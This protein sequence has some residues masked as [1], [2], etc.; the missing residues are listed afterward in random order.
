LLAGFEQISGIGEKTAVAM[1]EY[2]T[3]HDDPLMGWDDYINVKG[4]GP[5]TMDK[6]RAFCED[7]D[8]FGVYRL[9][10]ALKKVR[11]YIWEYGDMEMLPMPTSKSEDVPYEPVKGQHTWVGI[12]RDRNLKDLYE[13]HRSRTGDELDPATVKEPEHVNWCVIIG[14]DET[15]PLTMT[16]HRYGGLYE[17]YKEAIWNINPKRDV[18][19]VRGYKRQE[20]RRAIYVQELHVLDPDT[21]PEFEG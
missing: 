9:G 4:I 5:A 20:Y 11:R 7:E 8:P 15:G 12:V 16:V 6:V 2:R 19:V 10:Q 21:L 17:R 3:E 18:I 14:E 13:L 1:L